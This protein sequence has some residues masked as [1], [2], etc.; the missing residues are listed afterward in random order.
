MND[1]SN[2]I[3]IEKP[4]IPKYLQNSPLDIYNKA[5]ER[6]ILLPS[7]WSLTD[8]GKG[9]KVT[10]NQMG[11][12]YIESGLTAAIRS[13]RP[14][15]EEAGI[16]Y[17]EVDVI[18]SGPRSV[19]GI[20]LAGKE[21]G[22]NEQ[23]GWSYSSIG[24]HGDDGLLFVEGDYND[25]IYEILYCSGD[26]IGC[27]LNYYDDIVFYTKNG[28]NLG[29]ASTKIFMGDK[30]PMVGVEDPSVQVEVNF[31]S[32]PFN[33]DIEYYAKTIFDKFRIHRRNNSELED[34]SFGISDLKITGL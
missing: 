26:T 5:A 28:I 34:V 25:V 1:T 22:L 14:I 7:K 10:E 27:C 17:F 6:P 16:Y 2:A 18:N 3:P 33:F 9:I 11:I 30:Y 12:E 24:Y 20:G 19:I 4:F 15:P 31:G 23:P 32:R 29:I 8:H 13:E 21:V